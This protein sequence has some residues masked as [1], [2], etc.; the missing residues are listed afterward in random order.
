MTNIVE[1]LRDPRRMPTMTMRMEA[2]DEIERLRAECEEWREC[3]NVGK[4]E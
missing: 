3:A 2:A 1:R 4:S